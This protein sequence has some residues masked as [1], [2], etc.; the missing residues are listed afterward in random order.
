MDKAEALESLGTLIQNDLIYTLKLIKEGAYGIL[1]E[2]VIRR[3]VKK[4]RE[5]ILL[6]KEFQR[7]LFEKEIDIIIEYELAKNKIKSNEDKLMDF[8]YT[9]ERKPK[10]PEQDER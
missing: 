10:T 6:R 2:E 9:A 7:L 5:K 1:S 8:I 3:E 4:F